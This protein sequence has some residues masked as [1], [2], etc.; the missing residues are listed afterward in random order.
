MGTAAPSITQVAS[1]HAGRGTLGE[2]NADPN[3]LVVSPIVNYKP[4]GDGWA[5]SDLAR[6]VAAS[7]AFP[8]ALSGVPGDMRAEAGI[9]GGKPIK[10]LLAD[11]G[12]TD[13]TGVGMLEWAGGLRDLGGPNPWDVSLIIASDASAFFGAEEKFSTVG[14]LSRAVDVVYANA[15]GAYDGSRVPKVLLSPGAYLDT[16]LLGGVYREQTP[17]EYGKRCK[18]AWKGAYGPPADAHYAICQQLKGRVEP[19]LKSL[20]V[21][22]LRLLAESMTG[23]GRKGKVERFAA[24]VMARTDGGK[25]GLIEFEVA[26]AAAEAISLDLADCLYS[27][28]NASTLADR[29][30]GGEA[31]KLFRLGRMLVALNCP[32]LSKELC[33]GVASNGHDCV[34]PRK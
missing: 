14:E 11:G 15:A 32:Y 17:S 31:D 16:R 10:V 24:E 5:D 7:G 21:R 27:F 26:D 33:R 3:K 9:S 6:V 4:S 19:L 13:N 34:P 8:G 1:E 29:Y 18:D 28:T 12:I 25:A 20:D 30:E 22:A 2:A 23:S